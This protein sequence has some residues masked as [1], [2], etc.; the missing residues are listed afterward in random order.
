MPDDS[1]FADVMARLRAGDSDAARA[2]FDRF[3]RRLIGLARNRL[4]TKIRQ[5]VDPEDVAL[6]VYKSFFLRH[7]KGQFELANWDRL[8]ALLTVIAVCKCIRLHKQFHTQK[9]NVDLEVSLQPA[10]DDSDGGWEALAREPSP[11]E[12]AM[13]TETVER[14]LAELA[15]RDRAIV[16]LAL[17]GY[18]AVEICEQLGRPERTVYRVL[19]PPGE[20]RASEFPEPT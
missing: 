18:S 8:W 13:L 16:T 20:G 9:Q 3:A 2:V 5:K 1:S 12:A 19:G 11:A 17:Q 4:D 15:G 6:S 10:G 14:L 7:A